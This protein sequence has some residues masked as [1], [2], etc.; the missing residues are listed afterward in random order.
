MK[1]F[2]SILVLSIVVALSSPSCS[3]SHK[4]SAKS[5]NANQASGAENANQ[6]NGQQPSGSVRYKIDAG[7]SQ[8]TARIGV[9]GM[10][11]AFGHEHVVAIRDFSGEAQ[12]TPGSIEPASLQLAIKADSLGESEKSFSDSDRQKID[13]AIHQEGLETGKY[14]QIVFTSTSVSAR[15]TGEGQFQVQ[16]NG[17]LALHGVTKQIS[18]P[19]QAATQGDTVTAR[20][21]FT[22]KHSDYQMKRIS[23]VGGAVTAKD[24]INLSFSVVARKQ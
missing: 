13:G 9:E 8:F 5:E 22:I 10:L 21:E 11:K 3:K 17:N 12:L 23:A 18:I 16:I 19:A 7:A 15:K 6:S 20:G 4:E 1:S 2:V 14:Q 24:E